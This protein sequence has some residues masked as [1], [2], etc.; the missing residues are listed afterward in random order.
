MTTMKKPPMPV[1]DQKSLRRYKKELNFFETSERLA[2]EMA[3]LVKDVGLNGRI[4][5]PS[6]GSGAL[7]SAVQRV[8]PY[9][10]EPIDYCEVQEGFW[11]VL[12]DMGANRVG[13]DFLKYNPG[14]IYDAVIMN[15]PYKDRGVEKHVGHAWDCVRPGG[16]IVA[17]VSRHSAD[18]IEHEFYGHIFFEEQYGKREFSETSIRTSLF[19]INKP[20]GGASC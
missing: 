18:W 19:L 13:T 12:D 20:L 9:E 4:L 7:I 16:S 6:A 2:L 14:P 15:P 8:I 3:D 10:I 17:L 5:E 11:P 1:V